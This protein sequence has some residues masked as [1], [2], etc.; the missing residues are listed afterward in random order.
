MNQIVGI[1]GIGILLGIAYLLSENKKNINSKT[2]L[3]GLGLQIFFALVILKTPIGR[4][5][6][7]FFDTAI[8]K[9]I[10]FADTGSEF[11]FGSQVDGVGFHPAFESVAFRLLPTII[12]FSA[13][14]SVLY[15]YQIIQTIIKLFARIMQKTMVTS[16]PET[17][18]VSANIFV[19]Q[20]EAPLM[21]RP[22]INT[23]TRSE[24]AAVMIGGFATAAGG[25]LAI[26]AKWLDTIPGIAGHLMSASVMSAP[27]ALVVAKIMF[28]ETNYSSN[29]EVNLNE[30]N[31]SANAMDALGNGTIVGL[32][33]AVNVGAML[34]SFI[35][36]IALLNY[37]L[38]LFG[39]SI[40]TIL[41]SIF[42][43]LAWSMGIPW[44]ES[45]AV[46]SLMGKKIVF[47]E[48]VAFADLKSL[49]DS[50]LISERAAIIASYAL[51]GFA[52]FGSI[53]IQLGGIGGI[54][55]KRRKEIAQLIFKA[56][57]GGAIASWLT[58][59]LAGIL[60]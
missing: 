42:K 55:P 12:F 30:E 19:G 44:S 31:P 22:Y 6:F 60:L 11:L 15:H 59:T 40:E 53:G 8:T 47:T 38:G 16:G 25:V 36:I 34:I 21:I 35:S 24:L 4:P 51:C 20:T 48:F 45:S 26:Y 43:P 50:D 28:P 52:N 23:M 37:F 9:L 17:L 1:L 46:G 56:M 41:G 2:V 10:S 39:F 33:L 3:W 27:A 7:S 57:I 13:L 58:A 54:A 18:S 49:I 14:I 29:E 5:L 32:R